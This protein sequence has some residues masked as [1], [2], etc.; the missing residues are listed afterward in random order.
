MQRCFKICL[1]LQPSKNHQ[2][3][4]FNRLNPSSLSLRNWEGLET[5]I[6]YVIGLYTPQN[7]IF[8][9]FTLPLILKVHSSLKQMLSS[10]EGSSLILFSA[11]LQK[12]L[13]C[14]LFLGCSS[15]LSKFFDTEIAVTT[16]N[17]KVRDFLARTLITLPSVR[18]IRDTIV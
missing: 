3:T 4:L 12:A 18:H 14:F 5:V 13:L 10:Q 17:N 16:C 8:W 1:L 7:L 6:S 15:L 2:F 9:R 11:Q